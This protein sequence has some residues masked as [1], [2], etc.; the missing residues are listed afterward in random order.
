MLIG[1]HNKVNCMVGFF[2]CTAL[3][4]KLR[5]RLQLYWLPELINCSASS[6]IAKIKQFVI[7]SYKG[8]CEGWLKLVFCA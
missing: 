2:I 7:P 3:V 5:V 8:L 6:I 4:L 1:Y